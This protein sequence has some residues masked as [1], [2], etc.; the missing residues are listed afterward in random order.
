MRKYTS[1]EL[2]LLWLDSFIGLEY[3]HK[4]E[5]FKFIDGKTE[6]KGLIERG[7]EYIINCIGEDKYSLIHGSA[8]KIY[9]DFILDELE[10]K[11]ITAVTV[12]SDDYPDEL[13][14]IECPPLVLYTKGDISLLKNDKLAVV[15]SRKSL[16]LSVKIAE[17]YAS[18]LGDAGFTL[19][20]GIA[21]GVDKAVLDTA[22]KKARP[23][24]S[25]IAGGIDNIYPKAH[26]QL[27]ERI[28]EHGLIISEYP[29]E[30]A[31]KPYFFP[32]R[33]RII[34][35]LA[36]GVV[37][38]SGGL[39]SGTMYTAEYAEE[40][41][42]EVFAVPYNIGVSSGAG[43]NDLIKRGAILTSSP[44]DVAEFYGV[45]KQPEKAVGLSEEES[46]IV[47]LLACGEMHIEKIASALNKEIYEISPFISMLEIK[48]IIV[49][50]GVN[51]YGLCRNVSE[52]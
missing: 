10:R 43:C 30:V 31:P 5:L 24:I 7:R 20:T 2:C 18:E 4:Q 45:K 12:V 46:S 28:T 47:S 22:I 15:G 27:A 32:I 48:G 16:P 1:C 13:K 41:G 34:A 51:V 14:N 21:E 44:E 38:I 40:F 42:R 8:N 29:P 23:V 39:K 37:V 17:D 6:I 52:D 9:L 25:V 26:V 33:N 35:G 50:N 11:G 49:K 19:V 36:K 3:F